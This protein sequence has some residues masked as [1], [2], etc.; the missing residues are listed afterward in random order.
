MKIR[1]AKKEIDWFVVS[2]VILFVLFGL[3]MIGDISLIEAEATFGDKY[4]F[5]KGQALRGFL[6][7]GAMIILSHID[8]HLWSKM[9]KYIFLISLIPLALVLIP[10]IGITAYGAK[11]WISLGP[12]HLQPAELLKLSLIF[13][14]A[15]IASAPEKTPLISQI[16]ILAIPIGLV[17]LEPD[18]GSTVLLVSLVGLI[19]FLGGEGI[20]KLI[21]PA[22]IGLLIGCLL[23]SG[24]QYRRQR[25]LGLLDPF[26]DPQGK[27]YHV[28]Q[29]ALTLGSGGLFGQGMGNSRQKYQY[30][31]EATT[32]SI[33]ALVAEEFGFLG[34]TLFCLVFAFLIVRCL[35]ISQEAP[36]KFGQLVAGGITGL[37]AIQGLINLGAI[38]IAFPLTGIPFPLISY[39]GTSL[40]ILLSAIG[41]L[42]NISRYRKP[43]RS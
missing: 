31:P 32:D 36:D 28:Y 38:A 24:S 9:A 1:T 20:V 17:L 6:G 25:V 39:G 16:F 23:I 2:F 15:K 4:Y 8:Y 27:S 35:K 10:N 7:L 33:M 40:I 13:F 14:F 29:L 30:L 34:I 21:P 22:I 19:W 42:L 3:T 41:I 11:R 37:I 18:F 26:Y 43:T 5:L 12:I